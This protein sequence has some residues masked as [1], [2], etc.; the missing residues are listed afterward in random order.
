MSRRGCGCCGCTIIQHQLSR[1]VTKE[2]QSILW[3]YSH[4]WQEWTRSRIVTRVEE[5]VIP[6]GQPT[7]LQGLFSSTLNLGAY[8]DE[9]GPVSRSES[10]S[11]QNVY[12]VYNASIDTDFRGTF[13]GVDYTIGTTE[14]VISHPSDPTKELLVRET[15]FLQ[16]ERKVVG[17]FRSLVVLDFG[18]DWKA[19]PDP[20]NVPIVSAGNSLANAPTIEP[21]DWSVVSN[22]VK[23]ISPKRF[24][25]ATPTTQY[26]TVAEAAAAVAGTKNITNGPL[27]IE[28]ELTGNQT[29]ILT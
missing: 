4:E 19:H 29:V 2:P 13:F 27:L 16:T 14:T 10:G 25:L 12:N 9:I 21:R 24:L 8:F 5:Y 26:A 7:N 3:F 6:I 17:D 28:Y 15:P 20:V 11:Q 23:T 1:R 18:D 22:L